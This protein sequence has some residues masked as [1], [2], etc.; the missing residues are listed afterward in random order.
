MLFRDIAP[1]TA[2]AIGQDRLRW[3]QGLPRV[4]Q[5][6]G[7]CVL[8]A[9]PGDLWRAP[10][11]N[12]SDAELREV[13]GPLETPCVAYGHIHNPFVRSLG[14]RI[15]ANTGSV[16]LSYDGD[17]RASYAV[18]DDGQLTI[19]RVDYDRAAA[20]EQLRTMAYPHAGWISTVMMTGRYVAPETSA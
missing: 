15:V 3:L 18:F 14:D 11:A 5:T 13:Y 9:S 6:D 19:R 20:V 17:P 16:S 7:L 2:A 10:L 12:A 8:H 4:W 1:F